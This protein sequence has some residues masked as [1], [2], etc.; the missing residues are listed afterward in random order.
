MG[1]VYGVKLIAGRD[2][3]LFAFPPFFS[4]H[5]GRPD[6]IRRGREYLEGASLERPSW[7]RAARLVVPKLQYTREIR[8]CTCVGLLVVTPGTLQSPVN[9]RNV[10]LLT[11]IKSLSGAC[12]DQATSGHSYRFELRDIWLGALR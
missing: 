2:F 10:F 5:R 7:T 6:L 12:P 4:A 3:A 11:A 9:R 8:M 1:V